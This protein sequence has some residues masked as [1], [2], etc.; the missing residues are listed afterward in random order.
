MMAVDWRIDSCKN[1]SIQVD[2][3]GISDG[4]QSEIHRE[5]DLEAEHPFTWRDREP[6]S[7]R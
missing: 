2:E 6:P 1:Q 3:P 4:A 7:I 5:A